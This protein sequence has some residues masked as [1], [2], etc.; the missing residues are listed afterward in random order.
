MAFALEDAWLKEA[1]R[2]L[3]LHHHSAVIPFIIGQR[4][5]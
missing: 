2:K 4:A 1:L 3:G 5:V